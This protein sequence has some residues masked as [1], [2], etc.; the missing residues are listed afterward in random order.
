MPWLGKEY[1]VGHT[2]EVAPGIE[3]A[4]EE[5][6]RISQMLRGPI[7]RG[8]GGETKSYEAEKVSPSNGD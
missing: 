2:P 6:I 8:V 4:V 1:E 5:L 7:F 3:E